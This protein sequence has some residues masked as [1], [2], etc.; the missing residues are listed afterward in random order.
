MI[1]G[2]YIVSVLHLFFK[3]TKYSKLSSPRR[4]GSIWISKFVETNHSMFQRS[5][6]LFL[7][8]S[9]VVFSACDNTGEP[10]VPEPGN[11]KM[12]EHYSYDDTLAIERGIDAVPRLDSLY[13]DDGCI[14]S[15][16]KRSD[17]V[18]DRTIPPHLAALGEHID[19][20]VGIVATTRSRG[21]KN[22]VDLLE[23]VSIQDEINR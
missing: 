9:L 12:V 11:V 23:A 15:P 1:W 20:C 16:R 18:D 19:H 4:P 3:Y 21:R 14:V 17:T 10:I 6:F 22:I 13:R 2:I 5:I 7:I 8:F